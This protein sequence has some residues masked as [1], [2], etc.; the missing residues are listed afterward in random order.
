MLPFKFG[1]DVNGKMESDELL[2]MDSNYENYL[3]EKYETN[4]S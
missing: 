3:K 4:V 1:I 2:F